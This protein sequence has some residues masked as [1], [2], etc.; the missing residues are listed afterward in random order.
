M[1]VDP[2]NAISALV[3]GQHD[4]RGLI[5]RLVKNGHQDIHDELHGRIVI[6]VKQDLIHFRFCHLNVHDDVRLAARGRV[7]GILA[8][9]SI[10]LLNKE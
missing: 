1:R 8:H 9:G 3:H 10:V 6:I 4:V 2:S 5:R 7:K